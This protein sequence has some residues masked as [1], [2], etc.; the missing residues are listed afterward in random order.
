MTLIRASDPPICLF[1]TIY[2]FSGDKRPLLDFKVK[3]NWVI[4]L[5]FF[6][7]IT[8][9]R[10]SNPHF[11]HFTLSAT[12]TKINIHFL[13]SSKLIHSPQ[14]HSHQ[15][16]QTKFSLNTGI[17][18]YTGGIITLIKST[19]FLITGRFLICNIKY[20]LQ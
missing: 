14:I 1:R 5:H 9:I 2:T 16:F 11:V 18:V 3:G 20:T 17:F 4:Y 13:F 10:A 15:R 19:K 8:L 12:I 6:P 7:Y